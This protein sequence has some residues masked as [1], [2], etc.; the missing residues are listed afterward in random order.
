MK[1]VIESGITVDTALEQL[2]NFFNTQCA[3][4]PYLKSKMH[5]YVDLINDRRQVCTDNEKEY[6]ISKDQVVDVLEQEE[7]D[8]F[9]GMIDRLGYG[10]QLLKKKR[11]EKERDITRDKRYLDTAEKKGRKKERI[12]QRKVD[13]QE[14]LAQYAKL[15]N[16]IEEYE[17]V[18][19][20]INNWRF[21]SKVNIRTE[22][23]YGRNKRA[24]E[25][26]LFGQF[27]TFQWAFSNTSGLSIWPLTH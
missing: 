11:E 18:I 7:L 22:K 13:L 23:K 10:L 4:Y 3:D 2:K 5:V 17:S 19:N 24:Y 6:A 20:E 25:L 14:H 21:K 12:E 8:I 9:F 26:I 16:S 15:Q 27:K 1:L